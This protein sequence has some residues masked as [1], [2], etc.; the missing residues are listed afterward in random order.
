MEAIQELEIDF[1]KLKEGITTLQGLNTEL[2]ELV[3]KNDDDT[4][5]GSS[6]D[7][8]GSAI[9]SLADVQKSMSILYEKTINYLNSVLT[10]EQGTD[11]QNANKI[12]NL[13]GK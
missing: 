9:D 2:N 3:I 4:G 11:Q 1:D 12:N 8:I 5:S 6:V 10:T 13:K 7:E